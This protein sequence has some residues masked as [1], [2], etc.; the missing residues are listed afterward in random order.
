M[1]ARLLLATRSD[2]KL[3]ELLPL[4]AAAGYEAVHLAMLDLPESAEERAL[5]QFDTF[6]ENALAK[7]HYFLART[8]L[9]TIA[10]DSGLCVR[11]LGER[12]GVRSKRFS[13]R[14]D[15][16]GLAL[17]AANSAALQQAVAGVA[18]RS[19]SYRCAAAFATWD[20][21][22]VAE[23]RC[24]GRIVDTPRGT[25]GFGYDPWFVSD[26]LGCT[27]AEASI[28]A[29]E[30]VSHRGRAMRALFERLAEHGARR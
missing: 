6:A 7:A 19:A 22:T 24:T 14:D 21:A 18:D 23:G 16:S 3:R 11:A 4:A 26:D 28:E 8:G 1:T 27:F 25:G 10:D 20:W 17:D 29:K 5:E 30:A 2:G 13:G 12:P 15:L 9:P